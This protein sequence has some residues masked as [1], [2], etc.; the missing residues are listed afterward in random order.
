M[1][2]LQTPKPVD[3][4]Q[5]TKLD[6]SCFDPLCLRKF[7][8]QLQ[9][10]YLHFTPYSKAEILK[11]IESKLCL[12]FAAE[13]ALMFNSL[14]SA[15]HHFLLKVF[16]PNT[17]FLTDRYTCHEVFKFLKN[18]GRKVI[19]FEHNH[20]PDLAKHLTLLGKNSPT[21]VILT[22]TFY[23]STGKSCDL[24]HIATLAKT[25]GGYLLV[26]DSASLGLS[27]M[28][29][30]GET[31]MAP[32]I[33]LVF[34]SLPASLSF[35]S[36]F[37]CVNSSFDL[38]T[39]LEEIKSPTTA[40]LHMFYELLSILPSLTRERTHVNK[41]AA[42][43]KELLSSHPWDIPSNNYPSLAISLNS[44]SLFSTTVS[45]LQKQG[46]V[47]PES[48]AK[49]SFLNYTSTLF[50]FLNSSL[51]PIDIEKIFSCFTPTMQVNCL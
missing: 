26:D 42:H 36:C 23:P 9:K 49:N 50:F 44:S 30:M 38:S 4:E 24:N 20:T 39:H 8:P 18:H 13:N 37:V 41:L 46:I 47:I 19:V 21:K 11:L 15:Y 51:S 31:S 48:A 14:Q 16:P 32:G 5:T 1:S 33:D 29:S 12:D 10:T 45:N 43:L 6:L 7:Y 28:N 27:G 2:A 25:S 17:I 22:S 35:S 3:T 34:S 40:K